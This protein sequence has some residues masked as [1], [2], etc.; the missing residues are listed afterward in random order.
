MHTVYSAI[1]T[2]SSNDADA[3]SSD[4]M[5][6]ATP[7]RRFWYCAHAEMTMVGSHGLMMNPSASA[8]NAPVAPV[9]P[10]TAAATPPATQASTMP[11]RRRRRTATPPI[12]RMAPRSASNPDIKKQMEMHPYRSDDS[13]L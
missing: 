10:N 7:I 12:E 3:T 11:G 2:M 8:N 9:M 13:T 1:A 4:G 5:H 6:L